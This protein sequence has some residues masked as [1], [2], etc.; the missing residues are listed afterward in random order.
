M[1]PLEAENCLRNIGS[2]VKP[3]RELHWLPIPELI[4]EI[5]EG[6]PSARR[7]WSCTWWGLEPL[8]TKRDDWQMR[9]TAVFQLNEGD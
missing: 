2:I 8:N 9:Y 4:E 6:D 7:D 5:H 1:E 3:A